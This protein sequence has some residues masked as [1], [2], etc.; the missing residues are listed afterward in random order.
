MTMT[1]DGLEGNPPFS[2]T[3]T[4]LQDEC[5]K[6]LK[7]KQYKSC[8]I[9]ARMELA[10]AEQEGRDARVAWALLGDC[11]QLTQQYSR[12]ISFYRRI[13]AFGSQKY[14]LKEAQC[15][16]ALGNVVEASSVLE[17]VPREQRSLTIHMTL[18]NLYLASGRIPSA[19][20]CFLESLVQNPY[21]LEAVEWL[22]VL[23]TDKSQVLD[24]VKTGFIENGYDQSMLPVKELISAHFSK[25]KHQTASALQQFIKLEQEFPNN[26]YLLLKIATLQV[27]NIETFSK[28]RSLRL[29]PILPV[30]VLGSTAPDE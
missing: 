28:A 6:L 5:F 25:H 2:V 30:L 23:G 22:A 8:E 4:P 29:L 20:D 26:V 16:Q 18:G 11:A 15:L 7:A 17:V 1:V 13:Q 21:T 24:A 10:K 19:C 9:L 14:R 12:A 3:L 27:S